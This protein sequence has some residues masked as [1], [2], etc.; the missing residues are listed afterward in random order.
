MNSIKDNDAPPD[1][2]A[3]LTPSAHAQPQQDDI[4]LTIPG[5]FAGLRLDQALAKLL[6]HWSRSLLQSWIEENHVLVDGHAA[7]AKQKVW[8][9]EHIHI[10]PQATAADSCHTAEA[11]GLAIVHE[12]DALIVINK[13]VGLV[14]HP[15]NGNWQGTLLNALLHH[16]PQLEQV[17]RA[18]IVHRLDKDT[19]G[20]LVVAKTVIA[21][22][23]L[24][25]QLQ[26][27][28]AQ[29][30]YLAVVLGSVNQNG[31]VDAPV[32]RHPVH[33][34]K[35]AVTPRGKPARTHYHVIE[36]FEN[37]SLLAC[38]LETGRTHQIRVHMHSIGHPLVGD[39]VYGNK[40]KAARS[41]A[42]EMIMSFSRQALHARKLTLTHPDTGQ[43]VSWEAEIPEDMENL[44]N[45]LR[46]YSNKAR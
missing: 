12:D 45:E 28:T 1:Y 39:P 8:G 22:T 31:M 42:E 3:K 36:R 46:Q 14:T 33:R 44:L 4:E 11:I 17:P 41:I 21:Q 16:A 30:E 26:Q 18:G 20:L 2:S 7:T 25:R 29:R 5:D 24:V 13:P 10:V 43:N 34:T 9:N 35:M 38:S 15:G 19:S 27:H 32:G 37:C 6:P 23:H 40:P